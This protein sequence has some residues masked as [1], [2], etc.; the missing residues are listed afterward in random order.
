LDSDRFNSN[1]FKFQEMD[2]ILGGQMGPNR[3]P[4]I[5]IL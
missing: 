1:Q 4:T 2:S 5:L 3:N